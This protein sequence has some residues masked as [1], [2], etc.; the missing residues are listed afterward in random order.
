MSGAIS[1]NAALETGRRTHDK[2]PPL[3]AMG[4]RRVPLRKSQPDATAGRYEQ[5]AGTVSG[6]VSRLLSQADIQRLLIQAN[7]QIA[8]SLHISIPPKK[9]HIEWHINRP[10]S[11]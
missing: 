1:G 4:L 8:S 6:I 11:L 5:N 3:N 9:W 2:A 10:N 7:I